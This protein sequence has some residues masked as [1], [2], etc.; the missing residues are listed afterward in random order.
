M[1][2]N[3][4]IQIGENYIDLSQVYRVGPIGGDPAWLRYTIYFT[5]GSFEIFEERSPTQMPR[6]DFLKLWFK[7]KLQ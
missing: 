4:I 5:G 7:F 1:T 3:G 6:E 2:P